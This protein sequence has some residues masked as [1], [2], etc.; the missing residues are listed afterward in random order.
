MA[1]QYV[2]YLTEAY[3]ACSTCPPFEVIIQV[4][5]GVAAQRACFYAA[6]DTWPYETIVGN[7]TQVVQ[8]GKNYEYTL[9]F[10]DEYIE[11][12]TLDPEKIV[13][14]ACVGPLAT[15]VRDLFGFDP[16]LTENEDGTFTFQSNHGCEF[17]FGNS[18]G[19]GNI[20][21]TDSDSIDFTSSGQNLTGEVRISADPGNSIEIRDDGL[22]GAAGW[23]VDGNAGTID[24]DNFL[25]TLDN[26]AFDIRVNN[27]R[28]LRIYPH[29]LS[30]ASITGGYQLNTI[31]NAV[32]GGVISGGGYSGNINNIIAGN[33]S[34]ISGGSANKINNS[35]GGVISGGHGNQINGT[36]QYS[37]IG[38][39]TLNTLQGEY[40][41]IA[42]GRQ[43]AYPGLSTHGFIGGGN[44][45]QITGTYGVIVGGTTN[46]I[47]SNAGTA[48][49]GGGSANT[50]SGNDSAITGG[51]TNAIEIS[52][53][54]GIASGYQ[55]I[56]NSNHTAC[57]IGGGRSNGIKNAT[58][59]IYD[60]ASVVGGYNNQIT[61]SSFSAILGGNTNAI[62]D[63][64]YCNIGAGI[65][66][67]ITN[68]D[69]AAV[70]SGQL[71]VINNSDNAVIGG[72]LS[73]SISGSGGGNYKTIAGGRQNTMSGAGMWDTIGGGY[74]N[75]I[76]GILSG[77]TISG[78]IENVIKDGIEHGGIS[79]IAGG[80][81]LTLGYGSFGFNA[82][83]VAVDRSG[84]RNIA[85]FGDV[86]IVVGNTTYAAG[87]DG[88]LFPGIR[89]HSDKTLQGYT[90]L[91]AHPD[92]HATP[93]LIVFPEDNVTPAVNMFLKVRSSTLVSGK[94]VVV[95]KFEA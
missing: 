28:A 55:N 30:A 25:G 34:T 18:G 95:L 73:N 92:N 90:K 51:S 77:N 78:G 89:L 91:M 48:F 58:G 87:E 80:H 10:E 2:T 63:S 7:V 47:T 94:R 24:G 79:A 50:V 88:T 57:F 49:I 82:G 71:N 29:N 15:Y 72:G 19:L 64:P 69:F 56:I 53:Y 38:G 36:S 5:P 66:N 11:G 42:G 60:S 22:Y 20:V 33:F 39:G 44:A 9:E 85:Y 3:L 31:G 65:N 76:T 70:L 93:I 17:V 26:V 68:A 8:R 32:V 14:L 6:T 59:T 45:N 27:E 86:D 13:G 43:N 75:S 81:K 23:S 16:Q 41:T 74:K 52:T 84:E 67:T 21:T 54:S 35:L 61:R 4:E 1:L 12:S 37:T 40:N 46:Q 62:T 83:E